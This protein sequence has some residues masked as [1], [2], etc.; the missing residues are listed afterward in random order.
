M[1][2]I[3]QPVKVSRDVIKRGFR[4]GLIAMAVTTFQWDNR[5]QASGDWVDAEPAVFPVGMPAPPYVG[6]N[7][8]SCASPGNCTAVGWFGYPVEFQEDSSSEAFTMS[9]I[10]GVWERARPA[11]FAGGVQADSLDT[12]FTSVSCAT[13]GNCTAAGYFKNSSSDNEAFTM[14][15]T[16]GVWGL[17]RPAVFAGGVQSIYPS[18]RFNSIS[19]TSAENCTAVGRF[20]NLSFFDEAFTATSTGG[21]WSL[22]RPAV[23]ANGVQHQNPDATFSSVSCAT[24]GNCTAVGQFKK[25][26]GFMEAFTMSMADGEWGLARPAVFAVGLQP[27]NPDATFS[28]VSCATAENCTAVGH[29][30][31]SDGFV[32]AFTMSMTDGEWNLA[33]P[34]VFANGVQHVNPDATFGSVSCATAGNCT[35]V[36][37]FKNLDGHREAFTMSM[38]D[39]EWD[40]ARPAVFDNGVQHQNPNATFNS[41]SCPTAGNCTA[42]G[43][44]R[45]AESAFALEAFTLTSTNGVWG[46]AKPA[47]FADAVQNTS[48]NAIFNSIS[49]A[50]PGNCSAG[51]TFSN[52][53]NVTKAFT[54]SIVNDTPPPPSEGW[55]QARPA[56]FPNGLFG[57]SEIVVSSV[58]CASRGN[59]TVVGGFQ[60][61]IY[62]Q[63]FRAFTMTSTNG[64]WAP[65][66]AALFPDDVQAGPDARFNWVSCAS[67]GNCT[68]VGSFKNSNGDFEAFTM[69]STNGVWGLA[70]PAEFTE[71]VQSESHDASFASVSC[72]SPGNCTAVGKFK[73]FGA[74]REAFTM[75]SS[76]GVWGLA[77][78]A[79]FPAGVQSDS[80]DA[81]FAS[82]SCAS[83]GNC[84]AVGHFNNRLGSNEAFTMTTTNGAWT[85]ARPAQFPE[86]TQ[87]E[88]RTGTFNSVSCA[89]AGNC[90]AVGHFKNSDGFLEA[91]TMSMADG[92]VWAPARP[93]EFAEDVQSDSP[94][95][96]L[97]SV[98]CA[99]PGNCTAVGEFAN[100]INGYEAFTMTSTNGLWELARPAQF[101]AGTQNETRSGSLNSVS[102]ATAGNCT[103]VGRFVSSIGIVAAFTMTSTN[104]V[105]ELARP[106]AFASGVQSDFPPTT[107]SSVSCASPGICTAA[108]DFI[109]TPMG[110]G[111][112]FTMSSATTPAPTP[113]TPDEEPATTVPSPTTTSV[114]LV[115]TTVPP[116]TATEPTTAVSSAPAALASTP[117]ALVARAKQGIDV[118]P[119]TGTDSTPFHYAI[120]ALIAGFIVTYR[121][122][123]SP[124]HRVR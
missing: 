81:S 107:F 37:R 105:W 85:P 90:T 27:K 89:S 9:S 123:L 69:T 43:Q 88:S 34:A 12:E 79:E 82:V 7:S 64:V 66:R 67:P 119:K 56:E 78:P 45:N 97:S 23:F 30:K 116:T 95:A 4:A 51:G 76:G 3:W 112:M 22:A 18:A 48:P 109:L 26:D 10:N 99:S 86:N 71:G 104:G 68:A 108:G 36:G 46:M 114:P 15:S 94:N 87:H 33:R 72:A 59:C 91:F 75:T 80:P 55:S 31:N 60:H 49:C 110:A 70:R 20:Q 61:I 102:C 21:V 19:C 40:L 73:T 47:V 44:F 106:A 35:T 122:K 2:L 118:L 98:S 41:V 13:A 16:N 28:S 39:G 121:R 24:A 74:S 62:M 65:A 117:T 14:T 38:A 101:P 103:A 17:A 25:S 92:G 120:W 96:T 5:A 63:G 93:A 8:V 6:I 54:A 77:R 29:F 100:R 83:A 32:E 50:S 42:A 52:L 84:T 113:S 111:A 58:S 115:T 53:S 124:S 11:V 1:I 57:Y